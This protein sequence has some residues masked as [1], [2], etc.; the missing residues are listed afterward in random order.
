[1]SNAGSHPGRAGGSPKGIR[2]GRRERE[3]VF[4][5]EG[6]PDEV[7]GFV[8]E[9]VPGVVVLDD[10]QIVYDPVHV[11]NQRSL[12]ASR[13]PMRHLVLARGTTS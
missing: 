13:L 4:P 3:K 7:L 2:E 12:G 5:E 6:I 10:L 8:R 1:M 9:R 11:C